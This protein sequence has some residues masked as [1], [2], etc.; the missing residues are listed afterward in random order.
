[1]VRFRDRLDGE[2]RGIIAP[3]LVLQD[4]INEAVFNLLI[5][6]Q[7]ASFRQRWATGLAI[8]TVDDPE[9]SLFGQP[10]EPFQAAVDRLWVTDSL[11]RSSARSTRPT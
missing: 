1:M 11:T 3:L 6:L 10:V 4:R 5:A 8:P 7:F 9:S 2:N